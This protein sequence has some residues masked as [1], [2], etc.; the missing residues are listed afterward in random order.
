MDCPSKYGI[1]A[2]TP[3]GSSVSRKLLSAL[4]QL[5]LVGGTPS[6]LATGSVLP[7]VLVMP[8]I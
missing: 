7:A 4:A 3:F 8:E 2:D 1:K 6:H 5:T